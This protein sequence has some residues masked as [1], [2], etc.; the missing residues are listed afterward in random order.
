M[1]RTWLRCGSVALEK[2]GDYM[3]T[4]E[5]DRWRS[6]SK[7]GPHLSSLL[8][9]RSGQWD[10]YEDLPLRCQRGRSR[11]VNAKHPVYCL[12][13]CTRADFGYRVTRAHLQAVRARGSVTP[14]FSAQTSPNLSASNKDCSFAHRRGVAESCQVALLLHPASPEAA[15]AVFMG[16]PAEAVWPAW[17][18]WPAW[19]CSQVWA[20]SVIR[21]AHL[22]F[23]RAA[24][25][26]WH[27]ES[28]PAP[29]RIP[30]I[31]SS[32]QGATGQPGLSDGRNQPRLHLEKRH[33]CSAL[34]ARNAGRTVP[35]GA[36]GPVH[37][38]GSSLYP[39][40][41]VGYLL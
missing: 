13:Q 31:T 25:L 12:A 32:G 4:L 3:Q 33:A 8:P 1:A 21:L 23:R 22:L 24:S 7:T 38:Y 26:R 28:C 30:P 5:G 41:A 39:L 34:R 35:L 40:D 29:A 18:A 9:S 10:Y 20:S 36:Q 6:T 27:P 19:L 17:P 37:V 11:T 15:V 16:S 14:I 2:P